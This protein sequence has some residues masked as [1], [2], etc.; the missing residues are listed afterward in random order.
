MSERP[1]FPTLSL[2]GFKLGLRVRHSVGILVLSFRRSDE[3]DHRFQTMFASENCRFI[4]AIV[5]CWLERKTTVWNREPDAPIL[6]N[7]NY[8]LE[9]DT[10]GN[11]VSFVVLARGAWIKKKL[12]QNIQLYFY[13]STDALTFQQKPSIIRAP[14]NMVSCP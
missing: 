10:A 5:A 3:L 8:V 2:S 11:F 6:E 1:I 14:A 9:V 12:E 4:R 7:I 13:N